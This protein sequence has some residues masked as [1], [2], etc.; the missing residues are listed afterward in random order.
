MHPTYPTNCA[1]VELE[2]W[3]SVSPWYQVH[4]ESLNGMQERY[5]TSTE[6]GA[7][8]PPHHTVYRCE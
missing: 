5:N 6:A 4:R 1:Y 7:G 3:T 8:S 2:K